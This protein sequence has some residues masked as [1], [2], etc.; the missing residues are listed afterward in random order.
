M[1]KTGLE[2]EGGSLRRKEEGEEASF[3]PGTWML[4]FPLQQKL[5]PTLKALEISNMVEGASSGNAAQL[6]PY[7]LV[8]SCL[9]I[10][11]DGKEA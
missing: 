8:T 11:E 3:T 5:L 10:C 7:K 9:L 4:N 2:W 6:S 1:P